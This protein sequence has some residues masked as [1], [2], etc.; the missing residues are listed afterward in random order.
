MYFDHSPHCNGM[1]SFSCLMIIQVSIKK[2]KGLRL[3]DYSF[4]PKQC[5]S[6]RKSSSDQELEAI[7]R[8]KFTN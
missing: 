3:D 7:M 4:A 2:E 1:L 8:K 6:T 5:S